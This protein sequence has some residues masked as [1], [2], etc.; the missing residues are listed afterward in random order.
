VQRRGSHRLQARHD[1]DWLDVEGIIL[2]QRRRLDVPL[3]LEE[4]APLLDLK[5]TLEDLG[6]LERLL[7]E[8]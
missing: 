7:A 2:R 6:R 1:K 3:I 8:L 4:L 5:G